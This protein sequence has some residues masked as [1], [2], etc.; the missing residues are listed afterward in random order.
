MSKNTDISPA[1]LSSKDGEAR[2]RERKY[3]NNLRR[4]NITVHAQTAYHL[5]QLTRMGGNRDMGRVVDKLVRA[6]QLNM[7]LGEEIIHAKN[8][9][10]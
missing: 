9:L 2:S 3:K 8:K 1:R 6:H 5:D 10:Q 7:K 4:I